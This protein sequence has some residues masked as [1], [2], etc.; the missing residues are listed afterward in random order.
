MSSVAGGGQAESDRGEAAARWQPLSPRQRR[1]AGVLI[2]KAKTVPD[3]YPMTIN[4]LI[5]GCN[6]KSNRDPHMELTEEDI[7]QVLE[8]L[9]GMG[10]VVEVQGSGRVPKFKHNLYEW[11]GLDKVEI[12]VLAELLLRGPQTLGEL[13]TRASRME[14]IPDQGTLQNLLRNLQARN[15]LLEL[16]PPGRGQVVTHNVYKERELP[17]L[18][19]RYAGYRAP[20]GDADDDGG[21]PAA[22]PSV[23]ARSAPPAGVTLDMFAE[24]RV[25]VAELRA[26]VARLRSELQKVLQ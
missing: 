8:E 9:R 25:E 6:Q 19:V 13:R 15:L 11:F 17:E 22:S 20:S 26:E 23:A 1:V 7:E 3:S 21:P 18:K 14:P 2:E 4:G 24:L 16:T 12:A 10:A 5:S